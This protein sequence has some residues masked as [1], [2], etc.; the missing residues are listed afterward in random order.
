MDI[1]HTEPSKQIIRLSLWYLRKKL[2]ANGNAKQ[3]QEE[4]E[5]CS[6][7]GIRNIAKLIKDNAMG[8]KSL[9][10]R[11]VV[12]ELS[13]MFL[14]IILHDTAYRNVAFAILDDILYN[15]KELR[16]MIKPFVLPP[17]KWYPNGWI[18]SKETTRQQREEGR[19]PDYAVSKGEAQLVPALHRKELKRILNQMDKEE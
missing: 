4:M 16:E 19:I 5:T 13:M 7:D 17:E 10:Q 3:V 15:S 6:N 9:S 8:I 18:D 11:K 1:I 14:W 12:I 2:G